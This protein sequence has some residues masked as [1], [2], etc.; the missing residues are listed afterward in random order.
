MRPLTL[1]K[2]FAKKSPEY[3]CACAMRRALTLRALSHVPVRPSATGSDRALPGV[4]PCARYILG[5]LTDPPQSAILRCVPCP[6]KIRCISINGTGASSSRSS[7]ARRRQRRWRRRRSEASGCGASACLRT[8]LRTK[9][10]S[11]RREIKAWEGCANSPRWVAAP[12]AGAA[13]ARRG[14]RAARRR[15][16]RRASAPRSGGAGRP[17]SMPPPACAARCRW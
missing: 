5:P 11:P 13:R 4:L 16:R 10:P 7:V 14:R 2:I 3:H 8:W 12:A 17:G 15:G 1:S 6:E 9:P